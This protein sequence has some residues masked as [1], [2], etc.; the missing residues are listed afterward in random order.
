MTGHAAKQTCGSSPIP[1]KL[2][3][4][5]K[6][7]TPTSVSTR[8]MQ[9][10][11]WSTAAEREHRNYETHNQKTQVRR[12]RKSA[13]HADRTDRLSYTKQNQLLQRFIIYKCFST[14]QGQW[15]I[16]TQK[17][18]GSRFGSTQLLNKPGFC[19]AGEFTRFCRPVSFYLAAKAFLNGILDFNTAN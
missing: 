2:R 6:R 3:S 14:I 8:A 18:C 12:D 9:N 4:S 10:T 15:I 19:D 5:Q 11:D 7:D 16:F 17:F 13:F 1:M